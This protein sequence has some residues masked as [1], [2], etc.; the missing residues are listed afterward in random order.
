[1]EKETEKTVPGATG[2]PEGTAARRAAEVARA[3]TGSAAERA[4]RTGYRPLDRSEW[5]P[6]DAFHNGEDK[7]AFMAGHLDLVTQFPG[8]G[9]EAKVTW[10]DGSTAVRPLLPARKVFAGL[11]QAGGKVVC[12]GQACDKRLRV[13]GAK[14]A[15]RTLATSRGQATIP[16]W[17]FTIEGYAKPF[18][19][20]AVAPDL[21]PDQSEPRHPPPD[22]AG[23]NQVAD[24]SRTS[25][26]GRVLTVRVLHGSCVDVLAGQVYETKGVVVVIGRTRARKIPAGSACDAALRASPAEFRLTSPLAGRTVLDALSGGPIAQQTVPG[27][28]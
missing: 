12:P 14:A 20:P 6:P 21:P 9:S 27:G 11:I 17:E 28:F 8:A 10:S 22:I 5:L 15:A 4:W 3:W 19:Y 13:T 26:D 7:I 18:A 24:W 2:G 1:M 25:G 23:M 16:V